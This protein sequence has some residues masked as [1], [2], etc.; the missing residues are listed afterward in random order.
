MARGVGLHVSR[1]GARSGVRA[2][3]GSWLFKPGRI[4]PLLSRH[5]GADIGCC[6]ALV[7]NRAEPFPIAIS[8]R[9]K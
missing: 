1:R 9:R 4:S 3:K 7:F 2:E 5:S 6:I 8:Q